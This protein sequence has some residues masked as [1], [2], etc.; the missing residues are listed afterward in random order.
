M[1]IRFLNRFERCLYN[2]NLGFSSRFS[3]LAF[4]CHS[5]DSHSALLCSSHVVWLLCSRGCGTKTNQV[6][7]LT[8]RCF[9]SL[10]V[11]GSLSLSLSVCKCMNDLY[12][13]SISMDFCTLI[14]SFTQGNVSI[15]ARC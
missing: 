9:F 3:L 14:S 6:S 11:Y 1:G 5:Y 13:I 10:Y 15:C 2:F 4:D 8:F 12:C 7:S